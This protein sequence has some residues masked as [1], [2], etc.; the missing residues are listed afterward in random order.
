MEPGRAGCL[1]EW[2]N[3]VL[4]G[5]GRRLAPIMSEDW[6]QAVGFS[7]VRHDEV[8]LLHGPLSAS[9]RRITSVC[10]WPEADV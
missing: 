9:E 8:G 4:L 5:L 10:F 6:Q 2:A 3:G 7:V 1:S